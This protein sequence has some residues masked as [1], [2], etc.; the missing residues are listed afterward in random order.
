VTTLLDSP[1]LVFIVSIVALTLAARVGAVFSEACAVP[2]HTID[3]GAAGA[4]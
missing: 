4:S 1:L 2:E 3:V